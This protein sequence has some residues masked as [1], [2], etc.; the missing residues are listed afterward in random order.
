MA[1]PH[2][3]ALLSLFES[4]AELFGCAIDHYYHMPHLLRPTN[5]ALL[6]IRVKT[7]NDF[8]GSY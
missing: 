6:R 5:K 4:I 1:V 2:V 7:P 3:T 8:I